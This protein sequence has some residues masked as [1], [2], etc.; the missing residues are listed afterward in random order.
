MQKFTSNLAQGCGKLCQRGKFHLDGMLYVSDKH[1][2]SC[3]NLASECLLAGA[4]CRPH[5]VRREA[6]QIH[7]AS[8]AIEQVHLIGVWPRVGSSSDNS[9]AIACK[10]LYDGMIDE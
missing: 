3:F 2:C 7:Y 8:T 9:S 6:T 1:C 4:F 5:R 10:C